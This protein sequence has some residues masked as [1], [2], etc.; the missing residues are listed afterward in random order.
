MV[1]P[2]T[3]TDEMIRELMRWAN[4]KDRPLLAD[5]VSAL[6]ESLDA[7]VARRAKENP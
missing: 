1:T 3:L 2:E 6:I 7:E 4:R 5:L